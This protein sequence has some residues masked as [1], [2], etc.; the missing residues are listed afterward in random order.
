M[1]VIKLPEDK[2]YF[3]VEHL[4]KVIHNIVHNLYHNKNIRIIN[5][6]I[7]SAAIE[8]IKKHDKHKII[9]K[10]IET[11]A[12]FWKNIKNKSDDFFVKH[13][14]VVFSELVEKFNSDIDL[15]G[16]LMSCKDSTGQL[17]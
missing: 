5:P 3:N 10:F 17:A 7:I 11:S 8:H 2:F 1:S 15:F 9:R 13:S 4:C 6:G 16:E 14:K 12:P